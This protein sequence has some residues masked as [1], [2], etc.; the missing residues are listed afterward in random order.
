M[1]SIFDPFKMLASSVS[2]GGSDRII[3]DGAWM[4]HKKDKVVV[5]LIEETNLSK[6]KWKRR[7]PIPIPKLLNKGFVVVVANY[8]K[9]HVFIIAKG[10]VL[11]F[12]LVSGSCFLH[13]MLGV[14][15]CLSLR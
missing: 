7:I 4:R 1:P 2:V 13:G 8:I 3:V 5:N 11:K 14:R 15:A 6:Q 10:V 12:G 9:H